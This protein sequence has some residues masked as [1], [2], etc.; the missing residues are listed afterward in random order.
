MEN[1]TFIVTQHSQ[2]QQEHAMLKIIIIAMNIELNMN[3]GY[4]DQFKDKVSI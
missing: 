1:R 4:C 3:C 2:H